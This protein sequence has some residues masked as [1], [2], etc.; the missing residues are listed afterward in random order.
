MPFADGTADFRSDTVTRPTPEMLAAMA[1]APVGD[2]VYSDDPTANA[3]EE[4]AATV[5]GKEAAVFM[6]TGT[7]GNQIAIM[8]QTKPGDDVL[9]HTG[10]HSRNVEKGA[11]SA[12][13]GVGFR[14]VEAADGSITPEQVDEAVAN[15]TFYPRIRLMI[16][17]NTHNLLGGKV[18]PIEAMESASAAAR[19][20]G[21]AIHL[22][23]A[24][25]FNAVAASGISADA[26]A[27]AA[28]TVQFCFSKGLG[29]PIGSILCGPEALMTEARYLRKRMGGAMRQ[30]GVIAAAARVALRDRDRLKEDHEVARYLGER[31][32]E[33]VPGAVDL[34][35]VETNMVQVDPT[36]LPVPAL[37]WR[38]KLASEGIKINPPFVGILRLVT[39]R[40]V[41]RDDVDRL[42]ATLRG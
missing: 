21:L 20:H 33:A 12:L 34:S 17:E 29:A 28:D 23:G 4:E 26:F 5:V 13:S 27:Q 38:E 36:E 7:M 14:T 9:C 15:A 37:A 41:D 25:I 16:W 40:D 32:A 11:A 2:D 1:A 19:R 35:K 8:M 3:L 22:D 42:V 31:L 18:I 30:V 39:H 6:P 10:I 24:R